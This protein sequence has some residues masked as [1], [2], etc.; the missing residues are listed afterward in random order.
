M[1]KIDKVL[2]E[3][4]SESGEFL[5]IE[6]GSYLAKIVKIEDDENKQ[7]VKVY[8]DLT[9]GKYKDFFKHNAERNDNKWSPQGISYRSYKPTAYAF[10]KSFVTALEKSNVGYNFANTGFDFNSFVGKRVVAVFGEEEYEKDNEIKT[11]VK[12]REFRSFIALQEGKIEIPKKIVISDERKKEL[13][14]HKSVVEERTQPQPQPPTPKQPL[15]NSDDLP[16]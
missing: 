6:V 12:V 7:Y 2:W 10:L 3:E 5:N 11:S 1:S 13:A 4:T 8:I 16:F 14:Y 15:A 9:E